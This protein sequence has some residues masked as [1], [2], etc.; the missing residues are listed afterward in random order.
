MTLRSKLL[1]DGLGRLFL[2]ALG[3]SGLALACSLPLG[4]RSR[5]GTTD[6]LVLEQGR[7]ALTLLG[8]S[9][10]KQRVTV[11]NVGPY[12]AVS[13]S[14]A[15]A[16]LSVPEEGR[17]Q[18]INVT[19]MRRASDLELGIDT[20]PSGLAFIDER[21]LLIGSAN[22]G[23]IAL[24]DTIY[25][26]VIRVLESGGDSSTELAIQPSENTV[27]AL[28]T[29]AGRVAR[30]SWTRPELRRSPY[31]GDALSG[32]AHRPGSNE[33]WVLSS[34]SN[35]IIVLAKD[36]LLLIGEIPCAAGPVALAFDENDDA[37]VVCRDS[38]EVLRINAQTGALRARVAIPPGPGGVSAHPIDILIEPRARRAWIACPGSGSLQIIDQGIERCVA[39]VDGLLAPLRLMRAPNED[40]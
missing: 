31:L 5:T 7:P 27:W 35:R 40:S 24:Y 2:G 11:G 33:L 1:P 20:R 26:R 34:A 8:T 3:A 38:D 25:D 9:E 6:L 39:E 14:R 21:R 16:A 36:S 30:L 17:V 12:I 32:L 18:L 23:R 15:L 29:V 28:D 10:V 37:W 13:P 22:S 19:R 4:V